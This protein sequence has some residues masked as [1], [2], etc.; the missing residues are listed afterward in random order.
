MATDLLVAALVRENM[1]QVHSRAD[2][3]AALQLEQDKDLLGCNDSTCVTDIAQALGADILC[4]GSLAV[5][6]DERSLAVTIASREGTVL[7][8]STVVTHRS[9][10]LLPA[11]HKLIRDLVEQL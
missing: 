3:Q 2:V 5:S 4:Y 7:A 8:R 11:I 1:W 9:L 10:E 6:G